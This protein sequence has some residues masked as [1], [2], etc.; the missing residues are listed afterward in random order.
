MTFENTIRFD[1]MRNAARMSIDTCLHD[2]LSRYKDE[3]GD[4]YGLTARIA[5]VVAENAMERFMSIANAEMRLISIDQ[6]RRADEY[7]LRPPRLTISKEE[8][9]KLAASGLAAATR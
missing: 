4:N 9:D 2:A 1:A 6:E 7:I 3:L 5:T 8:L